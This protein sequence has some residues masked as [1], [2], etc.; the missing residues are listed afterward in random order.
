MIA[1]SSTCSRLTPFFLSTLTSL[2]VTPHTH[3]H[4]HQVFRLTVSAP[5]DPRNL[6]TRLREVRVLGGPSWLDGAEAQCQEL[7]TVSPYTFGV[8]RTATSTTAAGPTRPGAVAGLVR[9]LLEDGGELAYPP[10]QPSRNPWYPPAGGVL[11]SLALVEASVSFAVSA[12]ADPDD[13]QHAGAGGRA[14]REGWA[15]V[16]EGNRY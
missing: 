5:R 2:L 14:A 11:R 15:T 12:A 8:N 7:A 9:A 10:A 4:A 16:A 1:P 13:P 6:A 3:T